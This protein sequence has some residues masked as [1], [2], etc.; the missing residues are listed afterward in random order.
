MCRNNEQSE[1][2]VMGETLSRGTNLRLP[3]DENVLLNL[4]NMTIDLSTNGYWHSKKQNK[5][6]KNSLKR[7]KKID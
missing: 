6:T 3:F 4:S 2:Q 5:Q 7:E 1:G